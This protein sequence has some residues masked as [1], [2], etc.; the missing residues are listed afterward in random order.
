MEG[1]LS[2]EEAG[3]PNYDDRS[4][5]VFDSGSQKSDDFM[6]TGKSQLLK[7]DLYDE[8]L[9]LSSQE[10]VTSQAGGLGGGGADDNDNDNAHVAALDRMQS[11]T[12][13]ARD[14]D[15]GPVDVLGSDGDDDDD[16]DDDD[17]GG[18]RGVPLHSRR[19]SQPP[20][21][22]DTPEDG[23]PVPHGVHL[24]DSESESSDESDSGSD[25]DNE[26]PP[27]AYNPNEFANL[28]VSKEVSELFTY[29]SQFKPH[30]IRI[31]SKLSPFVP[32]YMPAVGD[33][34]P[35]LKVPRPDNKSDQLG[36]EL[37]DE[38][39]PD[40][41]DPAVLEMELRAMSKRAVAQKMRVP[42]LENAQK[43]PAQIDAWIKNI[44][45]LHSRRPPPTVQY[46]KPMPDTE[47]L[48][49]VWPPEVEDTLSE[50]KLPTGDTNLDIQDFARVA[51]SVMDVPVYNNVVHSMHAMFSLYSDFKE[52]EHFQASINSDANIARFQNTLTGDQLEAASSE[53]LGSRAST[54]AVDGGPL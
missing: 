32:D 31:D 54:T 4:D 49:Q 14:D 24:D 52:N 46:N 2:D 1:D 50:L 26:A 42:S 5:S 48:M 12:F 17:D 9:E 6:E 34:D 35:I 44:A 37:L 3:I 15:D 21:P 19:P 28:D 29:I 18:S 53:R 51:C 33:P 7:N 47:R 16:N 20:P 25:G 39:G 45:E 41:T 38:P 8:A 36:F 40:Q 27:G 11:Q 30:V 10:S 43:T 13:P 23:G 22:L